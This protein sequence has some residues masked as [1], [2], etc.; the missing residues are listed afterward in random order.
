MSYCDRDDESC[1]LFKHDLH[2]YFCSL[3]LQMAYI[4][5]TQL[6][7]H[8]K[9]IKLYCISFIYISIQAC[10]FWLITYTGWRVQALGRAFPQFCALSVLLSGM[11]KR[12]PMPVIPQ[13]SPVSFW[14]CFCSSRSNKRVLELLVCHHSCCCLLYSQHIILLF[15]NGALCWRIAM[16]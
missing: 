8:Y 1:W 10:S 6:Y 2:K 9:Y 15:S 12:F 5:V 7:E 4:C 16:N 11:M 13:L 3:L 14:C